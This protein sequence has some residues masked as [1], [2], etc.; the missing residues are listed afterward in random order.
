[1]WKDGLQHGLGKIK[2]KHSL[3]REGIWNK[4]KRIKWIDEEDAG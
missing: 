1:M 3:E 2:L 4:G